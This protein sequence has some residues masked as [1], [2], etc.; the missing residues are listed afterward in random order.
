[1]VLYGIFPIVSQQLL[2]SAHGPPDTL[3]VHPTCHFSITQINHCSQLIEHWLCVDFLFCFCFSY[4]KKR[5]GIFF[6]KHEK[7]EE[8]KKKRTFIHI[9]YEIFS[10]LYILCFSSLMMFYVWCEMWYVFDKYVCLCIYIYSHVT[11]WQW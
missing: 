11:M 1:M 4:V 6:R 5:E 2:P 10:S 7:S 8:R 3:S 9:L